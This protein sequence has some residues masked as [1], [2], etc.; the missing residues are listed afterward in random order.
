MLGLVQGQPRRPFSPGLAS[1]KGLKIKPL[2]LS[3]DE[4]VRSGDSQY[5]NCTDIHIYGTYNTH[6]MYTIYTG[7]T[8]QFHNSHPISKHP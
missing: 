2:L 5:L 4:V 3:P 8:H 1:L 6:H 7:Y